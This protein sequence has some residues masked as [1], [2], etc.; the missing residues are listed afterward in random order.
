MPWERRWKR[1]FVLGWASEFRCQD[2]PLAPWTLWNKGECQLTLSPTITTRK[3]GPFNGKDLFVRERSLWRTGRNERG[4][5]TTWRNVCNLGLNGTLGSRPGV[6]QKDQTAGTQGVSRAHRRCWNFTSSCW[7]V[8][9]WAEA[10]PAT[11][12][13]DV[14]TAGLC[15]QRTHLRGPGRE[16]RGRSVLTGGRCL[17]FASDSEVCAETGCLHPELR[18]R[19]ADEHPGSLIAFWESAWLWEHHLLCGFLPALCDLS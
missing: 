3:L 17:D 13:A 15:L 5:E 9:T 18:H 1:S 7:A 19:C 16:S 8:A 11:W 10:E 4:P 6:G 2:I 12:R 14:V